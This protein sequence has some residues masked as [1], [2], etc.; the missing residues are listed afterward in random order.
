[1][2][3]GSPSVLSVKPD[4]AFPD[5]SPALTRVL[6]RACYCMPLD[7]D[8][9]VDNIGRDSAVDDMVPLLARRQP[10]F[11]QTGVFVSGSELRAMMAQIEA[12]EV[13]A[14]QAA[15]QAKALAWS[16]NPAAGVQTRTH[17]VLMGYDFHITPLGP[18][19]IEINTNA[20]GAFLVDA[21]LRGAVRHDRSI[22]SAM[23]GPSAGALDRIVET[24]W[25]EWRLAGRPHRPRTL[26]IVDDDPQSQFLYP[27]MLLAK[28][29]FQA[30]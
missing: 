13:V 10:L 5:V 26:A 21:M 7:G 8:E 4:A 24:F 6:N 30:G 25:A 28:E 20:G 23:I 14:R 27:E 17:G 22:S 3:S 2:R 12:I 1:M 15:Y 9:V 29:A 11:A 19:L 16:D 18:R